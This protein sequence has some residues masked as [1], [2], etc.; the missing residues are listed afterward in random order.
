MKDSLW[1]NIKIVSKIKSS[2]SSINN[3]P[4]NANKIDPKSFSGKI[5]MIF[6]IILRLAPERLQLFILNIAFD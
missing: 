2:K 6:L 3:N 1:I 4:K 5:S